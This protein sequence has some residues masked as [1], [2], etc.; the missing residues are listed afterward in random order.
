[1]PAKAERHCETER[2][3]KV[4]G[5]FKSASTS[6][7][8]IVQGYL[9]S[10]PARSV[11][12]RIRGEKGFLTV[13]GLTTESG[14]TRYEWEKEIGVADAKNLL[15][16]CEPGVIEKIRYIVPF[17]GHTFEVDEFRG[18]N[19]GLLMAEI[20]LDTADESFERP[21]WLGEEVTGDVRYYNAY[22][23]GHP[24]KKWGDAK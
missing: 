9:S 14:T 13:K 5:D 2:K 7:C 12:V 15:A 24:Y 6:A 20:E 19:E 17:A 4:I 22:L 1:M 11:R 23:S 21:A 16:L 10:V 18:E 8:P 3:F